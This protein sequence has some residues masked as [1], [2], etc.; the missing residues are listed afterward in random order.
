MTVEEG[1]ASFASSEAGA[2]HA[3]STMGMKP[4]TLDP[5][6][7]YAS[8]TPQN[9][10]D[11]ED[12]L[13]APRRKKGFPSFTD[14]VSFLAY[15]NRHMDLET[16]TLWASVKDRNVT[17]VFDDHG[18]D[19]AHWGEYRAAMTLGL[20]PEWV[21]WAKRDR[22]LLVQVDFAE[23]LEEC[24]ADI[25]EPTAARMLE[26]ASTL[27]VKTKIEFRSHIR[28]AN[29]DRKFTY[30]EEADG[31]A[32]AKGDIVI[33]ETFTI[34]VRVFDGAE[35]RHRVTARL[36]YRLGGGKLTIGYFLDNPSDVIREAWET[37]TEHI[38]QE[39]GLVVYNGS[40]R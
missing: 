38:S 30:D 25:V 4:E 37:T 35:V 39:T 2:V 13:P 19:E 14:A 17:A 7:I 1:V 26:I 6:K 15:A 10:L 29:G 20:S 8:P 16:T 31:S 24:Q 32:G 11:L 3:I 36:R 28:L 12:M 5:T 21:R 9:V 18:K 40:P 33:P 23:H 22:Q 34:G 27:Q